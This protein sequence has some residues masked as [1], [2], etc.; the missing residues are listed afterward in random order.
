VAVEREHRSKRSHGNIAR[1]NEWN[2]MEWNGMEWN[3]MEW[4]GSE[5]NNVCYI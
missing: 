5:A 2:G 4:N 1:M 3:G